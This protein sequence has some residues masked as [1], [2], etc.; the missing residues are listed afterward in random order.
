MALPKFTLYK[1]VKVRSGWRY[2]KAALYPNGKIKPHV[3][4]VSGVEET[5]REGAYYLNHN[6]T[7]TPASEDPQ[8]AVRERLKRRSTA[9]YHRLHGTAAPEARVKKAPVGVTLQSAVDA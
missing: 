1:H 7:W 5:H 2:C 8:E 4:I 6:N 9:E 3:V